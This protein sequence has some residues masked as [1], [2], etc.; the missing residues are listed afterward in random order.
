MPFTAMPV[1]SSVKEVNRRSC[2]NAAT[3]AITTAAPANAA[4]HTTGKPAASPG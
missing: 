3:N 1:S 4:T 2:P